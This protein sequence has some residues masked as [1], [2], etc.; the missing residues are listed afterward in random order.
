MFYDMLNDKLA[1]GEEYSDPKH[2]EWSYGHEK[3]RANKFYNKL[4]DWE[5]AW[6]KTRH[7]LSTAPVGDT[8]EIVKRLHDTYKPEINRVYIPE[9]LAKVKK[10]KDERKALMIQSKFG[11]KIARLGPENVKTE[12]GELTIDVTKYVHSAGR[13]FVDFKRTAGSTAFEVDQVILLK[14]Q[15]VINVQDHDAYIGKKK[16]NTRYNMD[17][18]TQALNTPYYIKVKIKMTAKGNPARGEIWFKKQ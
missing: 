17:L 7:N 1:K 4:A 18:K 12:W 8:G 10:M 16:T 9:R 13:Y 6:T 14:D 15:E 3:F 11:Y 5:L 2:N